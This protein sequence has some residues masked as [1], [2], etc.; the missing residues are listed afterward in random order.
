MES[1]MKLDSK[2]KKKEGNISP[3]IGGL[4]LGGA[5]LS[6]IGPYMEQL[7]VNGAFTIPRNSEYKSIFPETE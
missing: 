4:A 7:S 3:L 6:E 5:P 2:G 1:Y